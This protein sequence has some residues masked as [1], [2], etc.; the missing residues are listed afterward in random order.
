MPLCASPGAPSKIPDGRL[1]C[2]HLPQAVR[3]E[4]FAENSTRAKT[5]TKNAPDQ[6]IGSISFAFGALRSGVDL[7]SGNGAGHGHAETL[8]LS[9]YFTSTIAAGTFLVFVIIITVQPCFQR[10]ATVVK[11][12]HSG[13]VTQRAGLGSIIVTAA[14]R[15]PRPFVF[16]Y[17]FA[18]FFYDIDITAIGSVFGVNT[19]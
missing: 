16:V 6:T 19:I 14:G 7:G 17:N 18:I 9:G 1:R 10:T 3:P 12:R 5:G 4:A 2:S 11:L 13:T 15:G 8:Q